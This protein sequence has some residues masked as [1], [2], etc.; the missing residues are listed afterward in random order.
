MSVDVSIFDETTKALIEGNT[1]KFDHLFME[2]FRI[3]KLWIAQEQMTSDLARA[4]HEKIKT[5]MALCHQ[6]QMN[7]EHFARIMVR[8]Q[9][10]G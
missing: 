7:V 1:E 5:Q 4:L 3:F 2:Q 10:S 9:E 8:F 6:A